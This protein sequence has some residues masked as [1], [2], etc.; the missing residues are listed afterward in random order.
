MPVAVS[1]PL[2]RARRLR[3]AQARAAVNLIL[4]AI[5]TFAIAAVLVALGR[6]GA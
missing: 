3:D 6:H 5:I 1:S 4:I 2:R